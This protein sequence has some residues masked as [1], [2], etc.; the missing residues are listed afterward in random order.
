MSQSDSYTMELRLC[1]D[2]GM[3]SHVRVEP[4]SPGTL[5]SPD[6]TY[7]QLVNNLRA[8]TGPIGEHKRV[9]EPFV[10][11]GSAHLAGEHIRC[12]SLSHGG[13][14]ALRWARE[15]VLADPGRSSVESSGM[16]AADLDAIRRE[17]G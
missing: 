4:G 3:V 6:L 8:R 13:E 10:C 5:L 14:A 7:L 16:S 11:T 2:D 12:T 17:F 1:D 15:E 9:T